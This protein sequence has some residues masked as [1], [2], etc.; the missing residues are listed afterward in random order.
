MIFVANIFVI[1]LSIVAN[2]KVNQGERGEGVDTMCEQQKLRE[3]I[4]NAGI[5]EADILMTWVVDG[6]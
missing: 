3:I 1:P 2:H 6:T 4:V 5:T